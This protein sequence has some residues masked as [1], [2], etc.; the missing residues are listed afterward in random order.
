M[1]FSICYP[2]EMGNYKESGGITSQGSLLRSLSMDIVKVEACLL[3]KRE[4]GKKKATKIMVEYKKM[5]KMRRC[6]NWKVVCTVFKSKDVAG[7]Q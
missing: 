7:K 2:M 1:R 3:T 5:D 6:R 4:Y